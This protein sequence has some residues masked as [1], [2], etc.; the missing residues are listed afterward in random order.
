MLADDTILNTSGKDLLQIRSNMQ[1]TLDQVSNWCNNNHMVI[2]P[3]KTMSM[4]IVTRQKHH[5][6][7][8]PLDLVL[9]W[10]EIDQVLKHRLLGITINIQFVGTHILLMYA[11]QSRDEFSFCQNEG[12]F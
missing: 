1:D 6:S 5:L 7:P 8:L 10:A 3:I 2:N 12:T 11:K 9:R 4:P